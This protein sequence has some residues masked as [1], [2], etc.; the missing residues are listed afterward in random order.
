MSDKDRMNI[1]SILDAINKI[2]E[3]SEEYENADQF[4]QSQRDFDAA[5][6]NFLLWVKW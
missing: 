5:M 2:I 1:L 4:Y 3:Y 6:M